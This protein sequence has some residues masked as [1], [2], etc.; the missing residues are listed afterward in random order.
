MTNSA[1]L[2]WEALRPQTLKSEAI[3][4]FFLSGNYFKSQDLSTILTLQSVSRQHE[5]V[6]SL[7]TNIVVGRKIIVTIT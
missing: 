7:S 3:V 1:D 4:N 6:G 5:V 2:Y